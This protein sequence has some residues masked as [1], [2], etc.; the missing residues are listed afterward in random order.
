MNIAC[1]PNISHDKWISDRGLTFFNIYIT[2]GN[3]VRHNLWNKGEMGTGLTK[4]G[5]PEAHRKGGQRMPGFVSGIHH[6]SNMGIV[7]GKVMNQGVELILQP[8]WG[9]PEACGAFK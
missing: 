3:L 4:N 7:E 5:V 6:A 1:S 9:T 2:S 8:P